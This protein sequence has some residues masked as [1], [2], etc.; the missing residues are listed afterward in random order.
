METCCSNNLGRFPHNK[1][2]DTALLVSD[3]GVY[4][5]R[6]RGSDNNTFELEKTIEA[7]ETLKIEIGELNENM[8][9]TFTV[10]KPDGTLLSLNDC[11]TFKLQTIINNQI[12]GCSNPCDDS[13]DSEYYP[14]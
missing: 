12:N 11:E 8:T 7:P 6:F 4:I 9:Y 3:L 2:I 10:E 14:S 1:Q 13:D 5:L